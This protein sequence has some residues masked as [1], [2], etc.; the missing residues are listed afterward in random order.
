MFGFSPDSVTAAA[1]V[2]LVAAT[3]ALVLATVILARVALDQFRDNR[4]SL[5]ETN[6]LRACEKYFSD[7]TI[8]ACARKLYD[9]SGGGRHYDRAN[10]GIYQFELQNL[11]NYL[12]SIA[13]GVR[14]GIFDEAL[15]Q[16]HMRNTIEKTV[17][18]VIPAH[19]SAEDAAR[20]SPHLLWLRARWNAPPQTA[21]WFRRQPR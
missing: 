21:L 4:R 6:T 12:E 16:D 15:V 17:D 19:V 18:R 13:L 2:G 5:I 9:N 8:L 14:R 10:L 20:G 3:V 7:P 11:L 1:T